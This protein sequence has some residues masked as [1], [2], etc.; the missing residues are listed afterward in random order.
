MWTKKIMSRHREPIWKDTHL[1]RWSMY[2]HASR[3]RMIMHADWARN[4]L[5]TKRQ[6]YVRHNEFF[7]MVF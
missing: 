7:V 1:Y 5:S 2:L 3:R 6:L 4:R